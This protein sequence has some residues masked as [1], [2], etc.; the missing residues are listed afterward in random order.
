MPFRFDQMPMERGLYAMVIDDGRDVWHVFT[1]SEGWP[2]VRE[3][4]GVCADA[5]AEA[6]SKTGVE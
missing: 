2:T 4:M 5:Y 3:A 1:E 6:V